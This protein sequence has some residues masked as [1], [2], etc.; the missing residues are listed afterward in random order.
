MS[1][2]VSL[3]RQEMSA[4]GRIAAPAVLAQLFQMALG[5][6]DTIMAGQL[7][8]PALAA[9]ATGVNLIVPLMLFILGIFLAMN[10]I[11]AQH[12]GAGDHEAVARS[13][14]NGMWFALLITVPVF[15]LWRETGVF[16]EL[17]NTDPAIRPQAIGYVQALSWG[18]PFLW[19]YL[20]LRFANEGLFA[21]KAVMV[22][23]FL[24]IPLNVF[25][26]WVFMYGKLGVPA[27]GAV[28][29]G[30]ATSCVWACTF[31]MIFGYTAWAKRH[32][33]FHHFLRFAWPDWHSLGEIL[34]VGTPMGAAF[35]MEVL[36]FSV[37]GLMMATYNTTTIAAHQIALNYA[38][39]TF[40]I[41]LGMANAI[42]ARVGFNVGARSREGVRRAGFVGIV[43]AAAISTLSIASMLLLPEQITA[44]YTDDAAVTAM[45]LS[46]LFLAAFYQ[47]S[48]ALQVTAVGALRGLK[49]TRYPMLISFVAYWIVGFPSGWLMAHYTSLGPAGYWAGMIAGLSMAAV[50]LNWRFA[51]LSQHWQPPQMPDASPSR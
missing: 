4:L 16:L 3:Y 14:R 9:V 22:V 17:L 28:G 24:A 27:Y 43:T 33:R 34:R 21:T 40:M 39:L 45:A 31:L 15:F 46:F 26:N 6:I 44:I 5:T 25:F 10:P 49:D 18:T 7:G 11:C 41:P 13:M 38:S 1:E 37:M 12:N 19:L 8:A 2:P 36:M 48:D 47:L 35:A 32:Q 42:T 50:L 23:A 51:R 20:S 29:T 30:Y